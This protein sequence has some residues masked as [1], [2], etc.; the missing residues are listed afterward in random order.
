MKGFEDKKALIILVCLLTGVGRLYSAGEGWA[1][2][3]NWYGQLG[4]NSNVNRWEPVRIHII[5]DLI[6]IDGGC[7]YSL[8]AR[9]DGTVWA[10]GRNNYGQLGINSTVD[11]WEP[12]QTHILTDVVNITAGYYHAVA[13][14]SDGMVWAWGSNSQGQCGDNT[15]TNQWEPVQMH[16]VTN[17]IEIDCGVWHSISL[18]SDSTVWICGRNN[19]GEVGDGTTTNRFEPESTHITPDVVAIAGG[20]TFSLALKSDSTLWSWGNN[21]FGQLGIGT[22]GVNQL[23]PC[24]VHISPDV[25]DFDGGDGH[26]VA[27]KSN[28]TVWS[29]GRNND[30]QLGIGFTGGPDQLLPCSTHITDV[31]KIIAGAQHSI[32]MKSDGTIWAWGRN[33]N[34]QLGDNSNTSRPSPVQVHG[35][36]QGGSYLTGID[37][38]NAGGWHSVAV[39]NAPVAVELVNFDVIP[40]DY[41]IYLKWTLS[42]SNDIIQY[43]LHRSVDKND[44]LE[45][46]RISSSGSSLLPYDYV[47]EDVKVKPGIQYYYKLGVVKVDGKTEWYGPV[48]AE[49]STVKLYLTVLPSLFSEKTEISFG[50]SDQ[51]EMKEISLQIFDIAG[52]EVWNFSISH[53]PFPVSV[54]WDG[55]NERGQPV[56]PGIYFCVLKTKN[57]IFSQRILYI[58]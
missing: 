40:Y 38:F 41:S 5:S 54:S 39:E 20:T 17:I 13:L 14:K 18:R 35:G 58:R 47:Y 57:G 31:V 10:W 27:L 53:F 1:W 12:V 50:I 7:D 36:E 48:S 56:A 42:Y 25:I 2:G 6:S 19:E 21:I 28:G 33:Q 32:A 37:L 49:V 51:I 43:V 16:I 29:W 11:Q 4:D 30:G 55:C 34:G 3:T 23:L 26:T 46:A 24:S 22:S 15:G 9:L 44:F 52:R 45:I 8:A